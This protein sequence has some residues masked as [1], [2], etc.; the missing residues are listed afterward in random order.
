MRKESLAFLDSIVSTPSPSGFEQPVQRVIRDW[1]SEYADE[2]SVDVNGNLTAALNPG[3]YPRVMLAGHCDQI[4]FMVQHISEDGCIYFSAIGGIDTA[5]VPG[6]RVVVHTKNGPL[7]GIIGRKPIH[8][9]KPEERAKGG[10]SEINEMW[11]DLGAKDKAEAEECLAIGDPITFEL[12][13]TRLLGDRVAGPGLDDKV[14]A[15]AV[16][17]AVRILAKR[18]LKC[19][20]FAVSTVQEELGLRGART[21]AY[22]IDPQAAIAVDVTFATD[23]P[24]VEKTIVGDL[25]L[26]RGPVIARG[27]NI[28]PVLHEKL[29]AAATKKKISWQPEAIS[30]ATGTDAN[31]IQ[32]SRGGVAAALVSVPNRYMHT[33]VEMISLDDLEHTAE[34][35]AETLASLKPDTDFTPR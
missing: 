29:V 13:L 26:D 30:R 15:F 20:V 19:A 27:P 24:H 9:Q 31:V 1:V 14:G 16:M 10:K 32:V 5:I 4:G 8:L 6:E 18:R 28:N 22:A 23:H 34:L 3:G 12:G 25:R 17:E 21:C 35:L 2:V 7:P 33:A 11:I